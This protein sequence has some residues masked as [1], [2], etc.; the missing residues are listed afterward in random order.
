M[1][2]KWTGP[3]FRLR[4]RG[5]LEDFRLTDTMAFQAKGVKRTGSQFR[6]SV[7]ELRSCV[8]G[9]V[10]LGFHFLFPSSPVTWCLTSSET[11]RLIRDGEKG[12]GG[13]GGG[14]RGRLHTYCYTVTTRMTSALK[15]AAM[16]AIL[17]FL[18][19]EGQSH[20]TLSTDHNF[21]RERR[22]EADSNQGPSA[23]QP[24]ALPLGQTGSQCCVASTVLLVPSLFEGRWQRA[25]TGAR[26]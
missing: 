23:H 19:C 7:S 12:G 6:A 21:W 3:E 25:P 5:E 8:N 4:Q 18:N 2:V 11:M 14:R 17:M 16:R 1:G 22:A 20:K 26:R 24:N 9:E 10:G 13:Y 15:W